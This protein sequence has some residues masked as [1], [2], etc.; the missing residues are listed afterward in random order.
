LYFV[1]N[2][3]H[4]YILV[5]IPSIY[6]YQRKSCREYVI[7]FLCFLISLSI[8]YLAT[9]T[10]WHGYSSLMTVDEENM[11][12]ELFRFPLGPLGYYALGVL[13]AIFYFEYTQSI[14]NKNLRKTL[15]CRILTFIGKNRKRCFK[16]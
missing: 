13:L 9:M 1:P 2:M 16:S 6:F 7:V 10:Y 11:Y 12:D 5:L 8:S 3:L 15:S 14:S 4:F